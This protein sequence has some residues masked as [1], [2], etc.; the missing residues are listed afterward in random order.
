MNISEEEKPQDKYTKKE[1]EKGTTSHMKGVQCCVGGTLILSQ[2]TSRSLIKTI[3]TPQHFLMGR[4]QVMLPREHCLP[5][6]TLI[7]T[8]NRTLLSSPTISLPKLHRKE[9]SSFSFPQ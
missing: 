4:C 2:G 6:G 7:S 5:W 9:A 8:G 1:K 3:I